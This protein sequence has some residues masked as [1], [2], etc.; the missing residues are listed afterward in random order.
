[1][2]EVIEV[3]RRFNSLNNYNENFPTEEEANNAISICIKIKNEKCSNCKF[4]NLS[5]ERYLPV[6][7]CLWNVSHVNY[8]FS[9]NKH[10][11]K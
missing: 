4:A 5:S 9:C 11:Y 10:E 2:D 1:M 8:D 6:H 7:K 3:L